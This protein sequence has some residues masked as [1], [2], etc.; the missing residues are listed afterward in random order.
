[1]DTTKVKIYISIPITGRP[2][3][4]AKAHA[5]GLKRRFE[6]SQHAE[7]ITPFD[8]C[9]EPDKP[10]SFYMGRDIEAL[11]EC[12]AILLGHGWDHSQGCSLEYLAAT[13]YGLKIFTEDDFLRSCLIDYQPL[14]ILNT[15]E[16]KVSHQD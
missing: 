8:I 13:I 2:M 9:G 15:D 4:E 11:L 10:Y 12:N 16:K 5:T 3:E 7:A 6:A 1:M 14:N